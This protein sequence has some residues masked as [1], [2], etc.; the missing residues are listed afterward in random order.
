MAKKKA[1]KKETLHPVETLAADLP[2]WELAALRQA[3]G[4]TEGKQITG[5]DFEDALTKLRARPQGGG[6]I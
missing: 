5:A 4:W 2:V 1:D 3:T 6:R